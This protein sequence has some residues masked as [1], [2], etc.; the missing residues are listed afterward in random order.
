MWKLD[1]PVGLLP[2]APVDDGAP[3]LV[4]VAEPGDDEW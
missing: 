1:W 3:F 2:A 4:L